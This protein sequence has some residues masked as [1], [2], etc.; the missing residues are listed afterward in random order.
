MNV[1][2]DQMSFFERAI[3]RAKTISN[4]YN[5]VDRSLNEIE[6]IVRKIYLALM[7]ARSLLK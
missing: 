6:K 2:F 3:E 5:V 7:T 4:S 1:K